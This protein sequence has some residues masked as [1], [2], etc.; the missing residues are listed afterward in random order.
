MSILHGGLDLG[1]PSRCIKLLIACCRL[2]AKVGKTA[3]VVR[4]VSFAQIICFTLL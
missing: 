1:N 3:A 4:H 2:I